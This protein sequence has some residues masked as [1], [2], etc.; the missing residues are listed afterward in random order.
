MRH[1]MIEHLIFQ[2]IQPEYVSIEYGVLR[3]GLVRSVQ[4][5]PRSLLR[6]QRVLHDVLRSGIAFITYSPP[7]ISAP[8][9]THQK[10]SGRARELEAP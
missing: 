5:A 2:A 6:A 9:R 3:E 10:V 7:L 8:S 4:H 1:L